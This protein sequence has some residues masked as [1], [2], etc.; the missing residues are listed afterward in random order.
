[1]HVLLFFS[2]EREQVFL[3]K[4]CKEMWWFKVCFFTGQGKMVE[5]SNVKYFK[6][7][8]LYLTCIW[9]SWSTTDAH[10]MEWGIWAGQ[11]HRETLSFSARFH[12]DFCSGS[13]GRELQGW[14]K[15]PIPLELLGPETIRTH[16]SGLN[17]DLVAS[18]EGSGAQV[19]WDSG[20][21]LES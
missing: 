4:F 16:L 13:S 3:G 17:Q 14:E 8:R 21:I 7:L 5:I 15:A 12:K 9:S 1:M 11:L 18:G 6:L 20:W 10:G 19:L 2:W